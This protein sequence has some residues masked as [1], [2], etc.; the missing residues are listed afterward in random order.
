M[1]STPAFFVGGPHDGL[2]R[3]LERPF[4]QVNMSRLKSIGDP[5]DMDFIEIEVD[6]YLQ[7]APLGEGYIYKYSY[8]YQPMNG[9]RP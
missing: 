2:L 1:S 9:G 7:Y 3:A 6:V 5:E 4:T 8:S